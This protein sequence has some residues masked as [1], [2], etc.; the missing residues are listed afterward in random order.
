L[1]LSDHRSTAATAELIGLGLT[2]KEQPD[3]D[4]KHNYEKGILIELH[5]LFTKTFF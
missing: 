3:C 1:F 4:D 5:L 2:E